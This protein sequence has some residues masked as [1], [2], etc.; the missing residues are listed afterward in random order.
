LT[1]FPLILAAMPH[2]R[3]DLTMVGRSS[4]AS[5]GMPVIGK[6]TLQIQGKQMRRDIIDRGRAYSFLYDLDGREVTVMDHALRQATLYAM[7]GKVSTPEAKAVRKDLKLDLDKTERKHQLQDWVCEEH[8]LDAALPTQIGQD[9][10]V[11]KLL[12]TV[13]LA[14]GTPEQKEMNA[15]RKAAEAP[16][17]LPGVPLQAK[18][19]EDQALVVAEVIKRLS[20]K[21]MLCAME[22]QTQYE[23]TGRMVELARKVATRFSL[24]YDSY[25]TDKL[26]AAAFQIPDGYKQLKAGQK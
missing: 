13:W 7:P 18:I 15:L 10:A 1:L 25:T 21:G 6:E 2:A 20:G 8:K 14:A 16:D 23:G 4:V 5:I 9:K 11:F 26:P 19:S 3:A 12:G 22:V 24:T 17:F